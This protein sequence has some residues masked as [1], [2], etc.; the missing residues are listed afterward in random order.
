MSKNFGTVVVADTEFETSGG[1]FNLRPGDLPV[2]LCLV[3]YVLDEN[4]NHVRT[5]KLWR[6]QLLASK[7]P[8]FDIGPDTL[9]VAYSAQAE[10]TVFKVAGWP[11]PKYIYDLHTAFLAESNILLPYEP[12]ERRVKQRKRLSDA[13]R[14][15]GIAGWEHVNKEQI[16]KDIGEGHWRDYG[17][18]GVFDYCEEDVKKSTELLR[19]M[20]RVQRIN[21]DLV[22][23]WSNYSAKAVAL[24]QARGIP[25]DTY[26]WGLI[27]ENKRAVIGELLRRFDPSHGDDNPIYNSDGEFSYA[28]FEAWLVRS[29]IP[30]WPRLDSGQL[31]TGADAFRLMSNFPGV[32]A[33]HAL[34]D[35]VNF[36]AKAQLPIGRDG[37]NR[38]SLFPFGTVT[39]RNAHARSI[40]NAHAGMRSL[41]VFPSDMTGAYLDW[42]TQEVGVAASES[43]DDNLKRAYIAGDIYHALARMCGL[44]T[45]PDP[46]RWKA[47]NPGVRQ[48]MKS[49]Q[50]AISYGMGVAS[51]ARGLDRHPLIASAIIERH[52]RTYP[53]FWEW[54][55]EMVQRAMLTRR[56]ES[57][58]GWPLRISTSPNQRTL[59]N[60]PMQSGGSEMLRLGG[61]RLCE[62]GIIPCMLYTTEFSWKK[63]TVKRSNTPRRSRAR[64][65][66][67]FATGLRSAWTSIKC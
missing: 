47:A 39:G 51:L 56:I 48:R 46:K 27:Q 13:C 15:Y 3:A 2:P 44:T 35:S 1:E 59:Y 23:H 42:R 63:P 14:A 57:C 61:W 10:L 55:A 45:D 60:F 66:V 43:D 54:R 53:R 41:I 11:F 5:I 25:I 29:G 33:I 18:D 49:L 34:R 67:M 50:L 28:R 17:Q 19:A 38:P 37:R 65:A 7:Y 40:Y 6:D 64:R 20:I 4:L 9:F 32:E 36:I 22:L 8:P 58:L 30:F 31:D 16:A 52:K 12:D 24:I 26:L 21:S 62:A